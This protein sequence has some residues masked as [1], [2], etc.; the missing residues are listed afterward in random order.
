MAFATRLTKFTALTSIAAAYC[1][2]APTAN[3]CSW[4]VVTVVNADGKSRAETFDEQKAR[5]RKYQQIRIRKARELAKQQ[6]DNG[7]VNIAD[8]LSQLLI[9]NVRAEDDGMRS[10]C[11]RSDGEDWAVPADRTVR[12]KDFYEAISNESEKSKYAKHYKD[13][14]QNFYFSGHFGYPERKCNLEFRQRFSEFLVRRHSSKDLAKIWLYLKPRNRS[15]SPNVIL[16]MRDFAFNSRKPPSTWSY[17]IGSVSLEQI[18][19]WENETALG[20]E[21]RATLDEFWAT[22]GSLL[23]DTPAICPHAM[24]EWRPTQDPKVQALVAQNEDRLAGRRPK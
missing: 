7:I 14:D 6:L 8:E 13:L 4:N 18:R 21:M 12:D 5:E 16:P 19:K 24:G 11:G 3:A 1:I 9:P 17:A 2:S 23:D 10:N 22:N 15:Y 20:K